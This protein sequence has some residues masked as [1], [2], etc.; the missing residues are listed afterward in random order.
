VSDALGSAG[1]YEHLLP[2]RQH[3]LLACGLCRLAAPL[4]GRPEL[5]GVLA[6]AEDFAD[7]TVSTGELGRARQFALQT[8]Q[9]YAEIP[10]I[11]KF[12]HAVA[13]AATVAAPSSQNLYKSIEPSTASLIARALEGA[14]ALLADEASPVP[15]VPGYA[16]V[17]DDIE[18]RQTEFSVQWRTET[19]VA[20]ARAMFDAR[21]F[22]AMPILADALQDAG[23]TN[24]TVL[25]HCRDTNQVHVRGCWVVDLVLE[26]N[27][28]EGVKGCF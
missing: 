2:N 21:D 9:S 20:L 3:R 16:A 14:L 24:E 27:G 7:G 12:A 17:F 6:T 25:A 28:G 22:S 26:K 13:L 15:H 19:A 8:A 4:V 5:L 1:R 23:C 18:P 11:E 10:H